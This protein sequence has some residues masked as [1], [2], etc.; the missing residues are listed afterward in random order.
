[1][2]IVGGMWRGRPIQAPEGRGTRPTTD[3]MRESIA[4]IVLSSRDLDMSGLAVLD[5][6]AGSGAVGLELLSR[7]AASCTFCERNRKTAALVRSNCIALGADDAAW[8]VV[9]GDV[10]KLVRRH[11]WGSP[12]DVV[13][14]DPPYAMSTASVQ[15]LVEDMAEEGLLREQCLLI[16]EHAA[17][18]PEIQLGIL[19]K[20]RTKSMGMS[21]VDVLRMRGNA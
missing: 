9:C 21:S 17:N 4:S 11:L 8:R 6:F 5:A 19:E 7:G 3:R 14:L 10:G 16:Y 18:T 20:L 12:F 15:S 2:R 13:F 1:M